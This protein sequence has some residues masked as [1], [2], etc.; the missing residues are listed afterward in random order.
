MFLSKIDNHQFKEEAEIEINQ[1]VNQALE[2]LVEIYESMEVSVSVAENQ[3]I[4]AKM[5]PTLA[6]SLVTNLLKNA[7]IHNQPNGTI[8][9][10]L[11][12]NILSIGNN[13]WLC[14]A[15]V[16]LDD[17]N[18][19]IEASFPAEEFDSLGG[20]V[21][22]LFGKIPVKFEKASWNEFDFIVQDMEGHR[23]NSIKVVRKDEKVN[24][25]EKTE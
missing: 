17:L 10:T 23:I 15:R 22:D 1:V 5:D 19:T 11:R 14:D 18:E 21:F 6:S 9:I 4:T 7:F 2:N 16:D 8:S 20:F 25:D 24:V 13:V 3:R 12:N